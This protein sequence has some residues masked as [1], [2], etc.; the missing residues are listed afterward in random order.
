M[1]ASCFLLIVFDR[2]WAI[3]GAGANFGCLTEFVF[4]LHPIRT[5]IW[6][7]NLYPSTNFEQSMNICR[8]Y[9][10][11]MD[12]AP[13]EVA[14][15]LSF[16]MVKG[17]P[18]LSVTPIYN[19]NGS[20]E[21]GMKLLYGARNIKETMGLEIPKKMVDT[22]RS[23]TYVNLQ[24]ALDSGSPAGTC[25]YGKNVFVSTLDDKLFE[26][27][28]R[29]FPETPSELNSAAILPMG[30][31]MSEKA[32]SSTA[33]PHRSAKYWVFIWCVYSNRA[34]KPRIRDW[35]RK[36]VD[37]CSHNK[38]GA[39]VNQYEQA[40]EDWDVWGPNRNRLLEL[41]GRYDPENCFSATISLGGEKSSKSAL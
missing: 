27:L 41:K 20:V 21:D 38:V 39:F 6:G 2:S 8:A 9:Q 17:Q 33:Y 22:V 19:G 34:D 16:M 25:W 29:T 28:L 30:R 24:K 31:K 14:T 23:D 18:H 15:A 12:S 11:H 40:S 1:R 32:V 37:G 3:R 26:H 35:S 10:R 4:H 5:T 7:F 36:M 13:P